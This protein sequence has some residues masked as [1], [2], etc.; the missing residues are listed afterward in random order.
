MATVSYHDPDLDTIGVDAREP[1][2][3]LRGVDT[4]AV[5]VHRT[6]CGKAARRDAKV[7]GVED[8]NG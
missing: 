7:K 3:P 1:E 5:R 2:L 4:T 8:D 6:K